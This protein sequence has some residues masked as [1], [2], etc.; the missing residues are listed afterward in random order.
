MR[1]GADAWHQRDDAGGQRN[2]ARPYAVQK[3]RGPQYQRGKQ[4]HREPP[5][6][7]CHGRRRF[8]HVPRLG[9]GGEQPTHQRNDDGCLEQAQHGKMQQ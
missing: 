8:V 9:G 4:D 6:A 2:P 3:I 7:L 1:H 5:L